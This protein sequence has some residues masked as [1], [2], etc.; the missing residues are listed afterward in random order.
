MELL[1]ERLPP[2]M[3]FYRTPILPTHSASPASGMASSTV[4]QST[5]EPSETAAIYGSVSTADIAN[6]V[7]ALLAQD[8]EG[9]RVVVAPENVRF[10]YVEGN[11]NEN[12][13]EE[14]VGE[15]DRVKRLGFFHV[16]I[17]IKEDSKSIQRLVRVSA[18]ASDPAM[19][20]DPT[21]I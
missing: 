14:D 20:K 4:G 8:E 6:S 1:S 16:R 11:A 18:Q 19:V 12:Q 10:V 3:E 15:T 13:A 21:A 5:A 2:I 9:S 17:Q 7:K